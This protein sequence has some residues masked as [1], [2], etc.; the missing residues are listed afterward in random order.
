LE[1]DEFP[2]L[3]RNAV[4][5][6]LLKEDLLVVFAGQYDDKEFKSDVNIPF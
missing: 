2:R 5:E 3:A 4:P 1:T 6:T